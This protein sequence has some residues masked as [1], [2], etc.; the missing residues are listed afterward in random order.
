MSTALVLNDDL[1]RQAQ[2]VGGEFNDEYDRQTSTSE[3]MPIYSVVGKNSKDSSYA[4]VLNGKTVEVSRAGSFR[5]KNEE[6]LSDYFDELEL[7]IIDART[8]YTLFAKGEDKPVAR[9]IS[10]KGFYNPVWTDGR[11]AP[12]TPIENHPYFRW[13]WEKN[14]GPEG[15]VCDPDTG[16][17]II[18]E[19]LANSALMLWCWDLSKDEYCLVQFSAGSLKHYREYVRSVETQGVKMHSILWKMTTRQVDNGASAAPSFVP[20]LTPV[21]VLTNDEYQKADVQRALLVVKAQS[22]AGPQQEV[23]PSAEQKALP[24]VSAFASPPDIN[25]GPS[26]A[27]PADMFANA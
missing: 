18:K 16:K 14:G 26:D 2:A 10:T 15:R 19:D 27:D 21:R 24:K 6:G 13:Y 5:R 9:G 1:L 7:V 20:D 22:L 8:S 23:L 25:L 3:K 11:F 17:P 12:G 4:G